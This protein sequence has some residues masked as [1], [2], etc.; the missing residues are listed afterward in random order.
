MAYGTK[1]TNARV[2]ATANAKANNVRTQSPMVEKKTIAKA[3]PNCADW[4][5]APVVGDTNLFIHSCCMIR[6]ATLMPMPVQRIAKSLG[7]LAKRKILSSIPPASSVPMSISA[8]PTNK[9]STDKITS[10][11]ASTTVLIWPLPDNVFRIIL[12]QAPF[13]S[14]LASA[15][16]L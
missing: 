6:P 8:A 11:N 9:E 3:M 7:I 10:K 15:N 16:F 13:L 4:I 1:N 2:P 14:W 12:L 5:V